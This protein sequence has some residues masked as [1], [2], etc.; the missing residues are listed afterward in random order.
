[1]M[2][3]ISNEINQFLMHQKLGIIATVYQNHAPKRLSKR[4]SHDKHSCY[5]TNR[6]AK[7][8]PLYLI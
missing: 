5:D 6:H 8:Q 4:H 3:K 7:F 2:T 1:M